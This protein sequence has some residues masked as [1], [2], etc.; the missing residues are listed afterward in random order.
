MS[1]SMAKSIQIFKT[2]RIALFTLFSSRIIISILGEQK[3]VFCSF[4]SYGIK[5]V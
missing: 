3:V 4:C 5:V 1:S 2:E